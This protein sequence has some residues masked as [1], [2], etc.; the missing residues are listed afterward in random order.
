L[1]IFKQQLVIAKELGDQSDIAASYVS[2]AYLLGF[3][4][5][6][7]PEALANYDLSDRISASI[8]AKYT[9]G[10][11]SM[12]RGRLLAQLGRYE[13]AIQAL[14]EAFS[15]ASQPEAGSKQ[16]LVYVQLARAQMALSRHDVAR[17]I[18]ISRET[19]TL[20]AKD[21]KEIEIMSRYTL[22][23]ALARSGNIQDA[24]AQGQ[25]AV[26]LAKESGNPRLFSDS[27]LALAEV[28]LRDNDP[29]G[30]LSDALQAQSSYERLGQPDSEW[31][32]LLTAARAEQAAGQREAMQ[33]HARRAAQL[34]SSLR[35]K[36]GA[37][38]YERYLSRPDI[39]NSRRQ[40]EQFLAARKSSPMAHNE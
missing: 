20:A 29:R 25:Q 14:D 35:E 7:Y 31:Q 38:A 15:L 5:E 1:E 33:D 27:L 4:L 24:R 17:A 37:Q 13:E 28:L 40:L 21:Y 23:L 6:R 2:L 34:L 11:N 16:L 39:Q 22:A 12:N 9:R 8:G 26:R 19:L 32:S 3:Y 18:A 36:W 30:A 10:Y